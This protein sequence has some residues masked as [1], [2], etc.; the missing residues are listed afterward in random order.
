MA[1]IKTVSQGE[2]EVIQCLLDS[3]VVAENLAEL[4]YN[5]V[6][7]NDE[8]AEKRF[9]SSVNSIATLL[10]NMAERRLH[11]LPLNHPKYKVK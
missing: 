10:S 5:L 7:A 3:L 8:V 6:P 1:R 11:R 4:K 9:D 2:Y